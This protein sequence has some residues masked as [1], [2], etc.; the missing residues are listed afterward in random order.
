MKDISSRGFLHTQPRT[1]PSADPRMRCASSRELGRRP[2]SVVLASAALALA[3][4]FAAC[5]ESEPKHTPPKGPDDPAPSPT[6]S[7]SEAPSN[8]SGTRGGGR[9]DRRGGATSQTPEALESREVDSEELGALH[10]E[11]RIRGEVPERFRI[12]PAASKECHLFA[13]ADQMSQTVIVNDGKLQNVFVTLVR[14]YDADNVPA[15]TSESVTIDQRGCVYTPHVLGMRAGQTLFV[16]NSDPGNHNV[17]VT[18]PRN[19][20]NGNVTMGP[21]QAPM[22]LAF[23]RQEHGV[24][25]ECNLHTWMSAVVHVEEHPWFAVSDSQGAFTIPDVPPGDY[26]IEAIHESFG[27]LRAKLSVEAGRSTGFALTF[28]V[29]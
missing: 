28:D 9:G 16:K 29:P 17:N 12:V 25:L 5:G 1:Q 21:G 23:P 18:A 26:T 2:R 10:G 6:S 13:D 14:G 22:E 8:T 4:L 7:Q 24:K 11:I 27:K 3:S 15:P 19:D 20:Q